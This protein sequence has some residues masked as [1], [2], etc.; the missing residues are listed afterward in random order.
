MK[1]V[2]AT[3]IAFSLVASLAGEA[4]AAAKQKQKHYSNR[5][6]STKTYGYRARSGSYD[7]NLT[8]DWYPHDSSQLPF[9]SKLWW[10]QKGR[11]TGGGGGDR[12]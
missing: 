5:H 4:S 1:A 11:E 7:S 12:N 3:C 2:L 6:V 9:G 10:E 8:P